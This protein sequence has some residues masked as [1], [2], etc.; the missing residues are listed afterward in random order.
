MPER[1]EPSDGRYAA[2]AVKPGLRSWELIAG[3]TVLAIGAGVIIGWVADVDAL[4]RVA[5]GLVTMKFNTALCLALLGSALAAG[6]ST[7]VARGASCVVAAVALTSL[8][9]YAIGRSL[10]I[11]Q[12]IF[13]DAESHLTEPG[14]MA[15]TTGICMLL[16]AGAL[17][18]L[19]IN[20][21]RVV[22][23]LAVP[24]LVIGW[25]GCLGY[26]FGVKSLYAVG[27]F[28]TMAE[29]T[30]AAVVI[31]AV[32]LLAATPDGLVR[33]IVRGDDPG[34]TVLRRIIPVAL[35]GMP[36]LAYLRLVGER[37]GWYDE[38]F[39]I[40]L[41]VV[42]ASTVIVL[43]AVH[44]AWVVNGSYDA[45]RRGNDEL[46]DLNASLETKIAERTTALA[47]SD[48]WARALAGTAP[49]GIFHSDTDGRRTYVNDRYC[50]IYGATRGELLDDPIG[51]RIYHDDREHVQAE[52]A[53]TIPAGIEFDLEFRVARPSGAVA[54]V[55]AHATQVTD[56]LDGGLVGT[57]EDITARRGSG[58]CTPRRGGTLSHDI[59][60]LPGREGIGRPRRA[61]HQG[62]HRARQAHRLFRRPT[63]RDAA[64]F[65]AGRTRRRVAAEW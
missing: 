42:A 9:E 5:P 24:V 1:T 7:R 17:C 51:T 19:R 10:G 12:L 32:G 38:A 27:P 64:G 63:P 35:V 40:A 65:A 46:H 54:W 11:D 6:P 49:I 20:R 56:T 58:P 28:A 53:R 43:V 59:R 29:H 57:L 8:T 52:W 48:A 62:Q 15:A 47:T 18:A 60:I 25:L 45:W 21:P 37:A 30:A 14:R 39:G 2:A 3:L 61:D 13:A 4:K 22:T 36:T 41:L 31:V 33:W 34:A 44:C 26:A 55:H 50:E 23:A 16:A